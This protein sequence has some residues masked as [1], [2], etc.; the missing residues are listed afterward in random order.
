LEK[1]D[2]ERAK[3]FLRAG[4]YIWNASI[5]VWRTDVFR[6]ELDAAAPELARVTDANYEE[7]PSI[8]IDYALMEKAP[9]IATIRGDFGWSDVGS[10]EQLQKVGVVLPAWVQ[11]TREQLKIEN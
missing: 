1:P 8:S 6:R 7:M 11:A 4:N 2:L 9:R 10:F 3:E 5:F